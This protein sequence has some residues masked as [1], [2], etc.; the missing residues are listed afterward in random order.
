LNFSLSDLAA[1]SLRDAAKWG[2]KPTPRIAMPRPPKHS[3]AR[4]V[5]ITLGNRTKRLRLIL[6]ERHVEIENEVIDVSSFGGVMSLVEDLTR[7]IITF[8]TA[9]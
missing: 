8:W 4:T 7:K 5:I 1:T 9:K 6:G 3:S 2:F